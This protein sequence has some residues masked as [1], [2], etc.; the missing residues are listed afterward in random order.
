VLIIVY[1]KDIF[2]TLYTVMGMCVCVVPSTVWTSAGFQ[3]SV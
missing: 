1:T 2:T 3:L